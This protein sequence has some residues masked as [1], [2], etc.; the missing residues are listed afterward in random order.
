MGKSTTLEVCAEIV[1]NNQPDH[2]TRFDLVALHGEQIVGWSFIW[3]LE[4]D[5]PSFGLGVADDFHGMGLGGVL[6]DRVMEE[7][8]KLSR[9]LLTVVKDNHVARRMYEKRGF[10]AYDE[11]IEEDG[12]TYLC[13]AVEPRRDSS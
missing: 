13:M 5:K 1:R 12:L 2:E 3:D 8:R 10:V 6:M 7:A 9:L 11:K 4:T